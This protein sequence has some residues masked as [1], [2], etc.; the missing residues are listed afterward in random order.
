MKICPKCKEAIGDSHQECPL[1]N[2]V[3][4]KEDNERFEKERHELECAAAKEMEEKRASR[5]RKRVIYFLVMMSFYFFPFVIGGS[6]SAFSKNMTFITVFAT[7]GM[8]IGTGVMIAGIIGGAFRCP[9]CER[10]LFKNYGNHCMY[11]GKLLYYK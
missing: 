1:C 9:Y 3:F 8:A 4:T 6:L 2:Y 10:I 5:A 7:V 11:C